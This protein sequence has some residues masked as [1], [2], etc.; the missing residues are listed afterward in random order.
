MTLADL[1]IDWCLAG[2]KG[3][4]CRVCPLIS[5]DPGPPGKPGEPGEKGSTG[6]SS[7]DVLI[8]WAIDPVIDGLVELS[9]SH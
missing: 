7:P 1:L 8:I 4:M 3:E 2:E 6:K 9:L 5:A